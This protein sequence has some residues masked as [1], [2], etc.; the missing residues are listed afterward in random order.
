M[1]GEH[2]RRGISRGI[3]GEEFYTKWVPLGNSWLITWVWGIDRESSG[4]SLGMGIHKGIIGYLLGN[5]M[6]MGNNQGIPGE[7]SSSFDNHWW[8][9]SEIPG[10]GE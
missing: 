6:G 3:P 2:S 10:N 5:S 8:F 7:L 4:N 9:P 1:V